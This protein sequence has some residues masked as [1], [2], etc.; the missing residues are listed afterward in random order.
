M[1][2]QYPDWNDQQVAAEAAK[3]VAPPWITPPHCTGGAVDLVLIDDKGDHVGH[4][5]RAGRTLETDTGPLSPRPHVRSMVPSNSAGHDPLTPVARLVAEISVDHAD[6]EWVCEAFA[7][8]RGRWSVTWQH[9]HV[10]G[11]RK[12]LFDH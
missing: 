4:G 11:Q 5:E 3:F 10:V 9:R 1:R 7:T 8:D 12:N 6:D 2:H